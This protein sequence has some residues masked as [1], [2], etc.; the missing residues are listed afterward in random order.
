MAVRTVGPARLVP[1]G[2]EPIDLPA[3]TRFTVELREGVPARLDHAPLLAEAR[4]GD[5]GTLE[6]ARR[7]WAARGV[8]TRVRR[9]GGVYGIAGRVVDNRRDLLLAEGDRTEAGARALARQLEARSGQ[10][11]AIQAEPLARPRGLLVATDGERVL[12][13]G[14]TVVSLEPAG[15]GEWLVEAVASGLDGRVAREDRRY[16]GRLLLTVDAA[17]TL[18]AVDAVP[19]ETLLRGLVPSEMPAGS[20]LEALKAQAVTAR[21]NVLAQIGTRHL[22]DPYALCSEVHC[23]AY[24]G[25]GAETPRTDEAV[26]ATRGEALFGLSDR[27]L[28]DGVYSSLCGGHT[29]DA[30]AVWG[31][32]P[33][34]SLRGQPDVP[35]DMA[36]LWLGGL[37]DEAR[38]AIFLD[39][40]P[41]A[42]CRRPSAATPR[43]KFRWERRFTPADLDGLTASLGVGRVRAL[44]VTARGA[45]GR[46][47]ALRVEGER[48][49]TEVRG[50]LTIRRLLRNLPSSM[51]LVS[52]AGADT[53]LR[54]GGWGHGAGMCQWGAIGRAEA[55]QGYGQILRAYFS[56]AEAAKIY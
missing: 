19:L 10:R 49:V 23:Q 21:S 55:G 8:A 27:T 3:G 16:R 32:P 22:G 40:P 4:S 47:L 30:H 31:G 6:L 46:A 37:A 34:A 25:V 15:D 52:R 9:V 39:D 33:N 38:L 42:F 44:A 51:F 56:G 1:R 54:G 20:P 29:E 13:E 48:G 28:V 36:S 43:E 17:G 7:E 53:V 12:G 45:S 18:A 14:N 41:D 26:R 11:V 2:G 24:R 50:E 35:D 5:R